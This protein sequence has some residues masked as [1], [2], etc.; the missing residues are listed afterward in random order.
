M[1]LK[2]GKRHGPLRSFNNLLGLPIIMNGLLMI[3]Q[4]LPDR[5]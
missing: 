1:R 3:S 5:L 4:G 2:I